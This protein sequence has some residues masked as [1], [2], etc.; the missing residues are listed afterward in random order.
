MGVLLIGEVSHLRHA[1][2]IALEIGKIATVLV[3]D[4]VPGLELDYG[5]GLV[6]ENVIASLVGLNLDQIC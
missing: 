5:E 3:D 2:R 6:A 4:W 1:D